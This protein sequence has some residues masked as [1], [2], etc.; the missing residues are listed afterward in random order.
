[1]TKKN[2]HYG[3]YIRV[4]ERVIGPD[5]Q[6]VLLVVPKPTNMSYNGRPFLMDGLSV[7]RAPSL[8]LNSVHSSRYLRRNRGKFVHEEVPRG[9]TLLRTDHWHIARKI[10]QHD[11]VVETQYSDEFSCD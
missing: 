8:A 5:E 2:V 11:M 3:H 6:I 1:M 9:T 4:C 7:L 10:S